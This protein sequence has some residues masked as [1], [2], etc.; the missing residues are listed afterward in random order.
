LAR[1]PRQQET[2]RNGGYYG[3]SR[4]DARA[5]AGFATLEAV[6]VPGS[7]P[8]DFQ[9]HKAAKLIPAG[10]DI[11]I[12]VHYTPN[13]KAASDQTKIGF[14]LAEKPAERRFVTLAPVALI[15]TE[16]FRIPAGEPNWETRGE[17]TFIEDAELVWLMPHMHLRGKDM[18]FRLV[19]PNGRTET[20]LSAK[21]DFQWQFG[22]ELE[23]PIRVPK[24]TK[25]VV[26]AHHDNSANNPHNPDPGKDVRWGDL[27]SEEMV[28]PWF[29]IIID[30]KMDPARVV[31]YEPGGIRTPAP[32]ALSPLGVGSQPTFPRIGR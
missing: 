25:M 2:S 11:R 22:Y 5:T 13:G 3:G 9:F 17:L 21:F 16:K 30:K 23:E 26:I 4:V 31:A 20:I 6:Y 15:D 14:T 24:G 32:A 28:M 18:T 27:T 7:P 29:G 1:R 10:S 19:Y 8:T 12:E